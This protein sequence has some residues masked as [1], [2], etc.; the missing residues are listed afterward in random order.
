MG[1]GIRTRVRD[2]RERCQSALR[3]G[4]YWYWLEQTRLPDEIPIAPMV[5]P[6]RYD[7]LIRK[8]FFD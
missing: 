7:I 6:L 2:L 1:W 3:V 4:D 5:A 8:S